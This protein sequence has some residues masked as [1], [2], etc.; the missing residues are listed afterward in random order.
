MITSIRS[1]LLGPAAEEPTNKVVFEQVELVESYDPHS[2][3]APAEHELFTRWVLHGARILDLG[4]GTG[5]TCQTLSEHA[6][7]YVGIDVSRPMVDEAIRQF[8]TGRF[9][10]GD[11]TDLSAFDDA[12]FDVV[13]FSY[14]GLD[15]L[16]P[17][18][19]RDAALR[20]IH[21]VLRPGGVFISS[22]HNPRA[23]FVPPPVGPGSDEH[24]DH[25][26]H[27]TTRSRGSITASVARHARRFG[28]SAIGTLRASRALLATEVYRSGHGYRMDRIRPLMTYYATP[29]RMA[30]ELDEAGFELL[31]MIAGDHPR[32]LRQHASPWMYTACMRRPTPDI[33]IETLTRPEQISQLGA[34][35]DRLS[36]SGAAG[37][38]QT[39]GWVEAW[40]QVMAPEASLLVLV[41]R[42][43]DGTV[44]GLLPL[45]RMSRQLHRRL[46]LKLQYL[47]L[48]G[49]GP[50]AG[51][52]LGPLTD[53]DRVATELIGAA[54]DL[55]RA[56]TLFLE[57]LAP[58]WAPLVSTIGATALGT[59]PCMV[60]RR[61][62]PAG[63][64]TKWS[65]KVR[66]NL[67]RRSH[68]MHEAGV[69]TRWVTDPTELPDAL[70]ILRRLHT[71]RWQAR[72][73]SGLFDDERS[74][75]LVAL[76]GRSDYGP[77]MRVLIV[78]KDDRPIGALLALVH[79]RTLSIYKTGWDPKSASYGIG[80]FMGATAMRFAEDEGLD[81]VDYLRGT[82]GHKFDLGCQVELDHSFILADGPSGRLLR[83]RE[84]LHRRHAA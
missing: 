70:E 67:R 75:F 84:G 4:V 71:G 59:T 61:T 25:T 45:A 80:T 32:P 50:G 7:E 29:D 38:F 22:T 51:D 46:P 55:A 60:N 15:Y 62:P 2:G 10:V 57:G 52:H 39:R 1:L 26:R 37:V 35:W 41:A 16:Y 6:R 8:P 11:A 69:T 49:S 63:F 43:G 23:V 48:A 9:Q 33:T 66:K 83:L 30:T 40:H 56:D 74:R 18:E 34:E 3:P 54:R 13:V 20:E 28:I 65:R 64:D 36:S 21:R 27:T 53:D 17:L 77:A 58:R 31:Q 14:N 5:R 73:R 68:R 79:H 24:V 12:S 81:T 76:A 78:E 19:R 47:G 82:G 44:V 42:D 72:G